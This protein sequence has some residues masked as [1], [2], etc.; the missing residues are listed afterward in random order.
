MEAQGTMDTKWAKAR[1]STRAFAFLLFP[2]DLDYT[3]NMK[4]FFAT[5]HR[6]MLRGIRLSDEEHATI[7]AV[8]KRMRRAIGRGKGIRLSKDELQVLGLYG[9]KN[10]LD[11][12]PENNDE[13][14]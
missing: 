10:K 6:R 12:E 14:G 4:E 9:L 11:A 5:L 7:E 2:Q 3:A 8:I 1:V 13:R